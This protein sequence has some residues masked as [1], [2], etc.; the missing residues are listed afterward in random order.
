[1]FGCVYSIGGCDFV[2]RSVMA[3][4]LVAGD[5][6]ELG[7]YWLAGRLG[8]GGQGVVYEGYDGAGV[9]VAVKAFR[10]DL[11]SGAFR[12][13]L[14]REVEALGRV[15]P[16]CTARIIEVGL[17]DVRP[18]LVSEYVPGPD[19]QTWV[20]RDGPYGSGELFRLMI[21]IA[22]ALSS[23]H[24][25]GVMH[26]DLKPANVLLGPDG[27][28]VIDF[29]LARTKEMTRSASGQVKGTPR[30][31]APELFRGEH[32]SPAVDVWAWG[33]I[34]LFAATGQPPFAAETIPA[35][36]YQILHHDPD[37]AVLQ[38]PLRSL[39]GRALSRSPELRPG[40]MELL[41]GLIDGESEDSSLEAGER[42]AG[43]LPV[44]SIAPSLAQ[45]AEQAYARLEP[46]AQT[47]V[48]RVLLRMIAAASDADRT[49]RRVAAEEV[50]DAETDEQNV[51]QVLDGFRDAGLLVRDGELFTLATPALV[52]AWP[53]L[54]EWV[55]D[56]RDA[57][58]VHHRLTDG[59]RRWN[60]HGRKGGDLL[61]GT[62]LDEAVTW[63]V[64]SHRHLTLNPLERSFLDHS[65][66]AARRTSRN[67]TL[68]SA[69]LAILLIVA[70]VTAAVAGA[71]SHAVSLQRDIVVHQR[72]Q[73]VGARIAGVAT[74]MRRSDPATAKQLAVAA[75]SLSPDS[76]EA[77]NAL[78]TLFNQPEQF[79]YRPPGVDGTWKSTADATGHLRAYVRGNEVK[80]AG[81]DAR[82][83]RSS[84]RFSGKP[85]D[86]RL[87]VS[88]AS[89][90]SDG[91][92]LSLLR[93]DHTIGVYDAMTGRQ[94]PATFRAP[95]PAQGLDRN[96]RRLL[97]GE[98]KGVSV[99]DTTSGKPLLKIPDAEGAVDFTPDGNYLVTTHGTTVDL[100]DLDTK[101]KAR[102]L[103]PVPGKEA[104]TTFALSPDGRFIALRQGDRRLWVGPFDR[105]NPLQMT[106]FTIPKSV[107]DNEKIFNTELIFSSDSRYVAVQGTV[108]ETPN[109]QEGI[110]T[111]QEPVFRYSK[112]GCSHYTFGPG[113]RTL[114]CVTFEN[115][116]T[117][118]S[119]G[120]IRDPVKLVGP[121][122][123]PRD[124]ML[125]QDGS[126]LITS[127]I[128][129][130]TMEI[131]DPTKRVRRGALPFGDN[132]VV[133]ELSADGRLLAKAHPN[134]DIEIWDVPSATRK[135][136][137]ATHRHLENEVFTGDTAQIGF[138]PD[139]RTLAVLT[140]ATG[141]ASLL[142]LWDIASRT[143]RAAST[144]QPPA[145]GGE[146]D[147]TEAQ[148]FDVRILFSG[149]S[150]TV[151]SSPDQGV[152]DVAT[153]RRLIAPNF[154]VGAP[155]AVSKNGVVAAEDPDQK[156]ALWDGRSLR[157][158]DDTT[159]SGSPL[160]PAAFSPDGR[161]LAVADEMTDQIRLWDLTRR[162]GLGGPLSGFFRDRE[163][164]AG[165]T[166]R[167]VAFAPDGS[168]VLA[169]DSD[170]RLRTHLVAPGKVKA[171]LCA[172]FGPLSRAAWK[173]H[174]P[175]IPYQNTC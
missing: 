87:L 91:R 32:A 7:S 144:G 138:S 128:N 51:H 42:A 164:F 94:F 38:E 2:E 82:T 18:Y 26:R 88:V 131:W 46:A 22:T 36:A 130:S 53:R 45:V 50:I 163:D 116:V 19:L 167:W 108:W 84:F 31:M 52:R 111:E 43:D 106:S 16:Y 83:V 99:W 136:I 15:A 49:L 155:R 96:G 59:A 120:A 161:L 12:G 47:V 39:V 149:D 126:T 152:V 110:L 125:S 112:P 35:L 48:P 54:R 162:Q 168:A 109:P 63:A 115:I 23:I 153:G 154:A 62:P 77:R 17:D 95:T 74:T 121:Q 57:L 20:E 133:V 56:E 100:W 160:A 78:L 14:R 3:D 30:W 8:A 25:A 81:V 34:A 117:V 80:V 105:A 70:A 41:E 122:E 68:L 33:A 58:D 37:L 172:Q 89:L 151:V 5:P 101:R 1:L 166:I 79:T 141:R 61:H 90:S 29:G 165:P 27:P 140:N 104:I 150:R 142:E 65:V 173:T 156:I 114:R 40:A 103:R 75:E 171:A 148:T 71:Q 119:L 146:R 21:G 159:L 92:V 124:P 98:R 76:Y 28:R 135:A 4:P 6:R 55:A 24:R 175:E 67:R 72:D 132:I 93:Q 158:V 169:I 174:I 86:T 73:A 123:H 69:A 9:R 134:G 107:T 113:D 129:T 10:G 170:G 127:V 13:Q 60:D 147:Q 64:A 44:T 145:G 66:R 85:L 137:L 97:V 102:T 157:R 11:V 143:R 118:L 139:G